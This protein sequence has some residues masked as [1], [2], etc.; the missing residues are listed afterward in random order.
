MILLVKVYYFIT[1]YKYMLLIAI[2]QRSRTTRLYI[3]MTL[4]L[5]RVTA[6]SNWQRYQVLPDSTK[7]LHKMFL[8]YFNIYFYV[9]IISIV[10]TSSIRENNTVLR[11][12]QIG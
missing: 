3:V 2:K 4:L 8:I 6:L 10:N 11:D 12:Y 9:I 1:T 5:K 7:K